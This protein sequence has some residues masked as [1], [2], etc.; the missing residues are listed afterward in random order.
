MKIQFS[1]HN[2][3]MRI[4]HRESSVPYKL[5]QHLYVQV[6]GIPYKEAWTQLSNTAWVSRMPHI[7][8]KHMLQEL[9][10]QDW[11]IYYWRD[12]VEDEEDLILNGAP[13]GLIVGRYCMNLTAWILSNT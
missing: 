12:R 3:I 4:A 10:A 9:K 13:E 1:S 11:K 5:F 2:D 6:Y 7:D 8:L